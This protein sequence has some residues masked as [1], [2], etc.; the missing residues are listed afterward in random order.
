MGKESNAPPMPMRQRQRG[1]FRKEEL[2]LSEEGF[3]R[4]Q[5]AEFSDQ[6]ARPA[7][8]LPNG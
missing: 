4:G 6:A 2:P 7:G 1:K 5:R 3:Y 8:F